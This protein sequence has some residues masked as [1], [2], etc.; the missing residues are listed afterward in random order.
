[1][2]AV[3]GSVRENLEEVAQGA[4]RIAGRIVVGGMLAAAALGV[5]A[6]APSDASAQSAGTQI[7]ATNTPTPIAVTP[8]VAASVPR[9]VCVQANTIFTDYVRANISNF[10]ATDREQ[11]Q[12]LSRWM[13]AGCQ[14]TVRL[15]A[16]LPE[17]WAAT[18][19]IQTRIGKSRYDFGRVLS[20]G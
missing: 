14:G 12:I 11:L 18:T 3:L 9:D 7:A 13:G 15:R 20:L 4:G 19:H 5:S 16:G 17:V 2:S 6:L 8:N 1:M 10:S